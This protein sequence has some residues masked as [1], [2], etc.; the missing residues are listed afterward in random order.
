MLCYVSSEHCYQK[1]GASW[2][3]PDEAGQWKAAVKEE[4]EVKR[5]NA[6][7]TKL[8]VLIIVPLNETN[9]PLTILL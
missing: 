3:T 7:G 5:V 8:L 4:Q 6:L 1:P 9:S 2:E